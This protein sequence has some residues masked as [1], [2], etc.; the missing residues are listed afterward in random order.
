MENENETLNTQIKQA[1]KKFKDSN[2]KISANLFKTATS[3]LHT[4]Q[5]EKTIIPVRDNDD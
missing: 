1:T 5:L 2:T 4:D 3:L